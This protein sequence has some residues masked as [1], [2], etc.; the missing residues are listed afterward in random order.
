MTINLCSI[1]LHGVFVGCLVICQMP[2]DEIAMLIL[3]ITVD[4]S[5]NESYHFDANVANVVSAKCFAERTTPASRHLS[6]RLLQY[7]NIEIKQSP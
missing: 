6:G 5:P 4:L 2:L 3:G 1:S 7:A